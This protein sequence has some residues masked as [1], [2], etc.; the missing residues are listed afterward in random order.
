[1]SFESR[2]KKIHISVG[3]FSSIS[4]PLEGLI[5]GAGGASA[6]SGGRGVAQEAVTGTDL[7]LPRARVTVPLVVPQ[8]W[9]QHSSFVVV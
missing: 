1:M 6:S 4:K 9:I 5:S 3:E 8:G 2:G 7:S